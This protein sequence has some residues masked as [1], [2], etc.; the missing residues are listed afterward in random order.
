M[1]GLVLVAAPVDVQAIRLAE[2]L[3]YSKI[4]D[5]VRDDPIAEADMA[6]QLCEKADYFI[7]TCGN[8]HCRKA[9]IYRE[10]VPLVYLPHRKS[11]YCSIKCRDQQKA[12][13]WY[14]RSRNSDPDYIPAMMRKA[15]ARSRP[16]RVPMNA[17]KKR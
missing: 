1:D 6:L 2:L 12:R 4:L 7:K 9:F 17:K 3:G 14:Y 16:P 11:K 13:E 15:L 5:A 10:P 8:D